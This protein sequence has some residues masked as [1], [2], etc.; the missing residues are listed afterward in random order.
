H[1]TQP[2]KDS[3]TLNRVGGDF[4]SQIDGSLTANGNLIIVNPNGIIFGSSAMVDLGGLIASS[5]NILND[6]FM[7]AGSLKFNLP[8]YKHAAIIN[9]GKINIR[10]AGVLGFVAPHV[11]NAG[12]IKG[13]LSKVSLGSGD[14]FT[15]DLFGDKLIEL[16][17]TD[18]LESQS[19]RM[20]GVIDNKGGIIELSA[21]KARNAIDSIIDV[22]G[23]MVATSIAERDGKII[24]LDADG[25][26]AGGEI[27][28]GGA[29]Q[30]GP[31]LPSS[32][33]SYV[34]PDVKISSSGTNG[35]GGK[36]IVWADKNLVYSGHT[37]AEGGASG[38]GG[39]VE[40]SGKVFTINGSASVKGGL[41]PGEW[42]LDPN[43]ITITGATL[44]MSAGPNFTSTDDSATLNVISI[45]TALD[46]GGDVT[47][48][49]GAG[50]ANSQGGN[51]IIAADIVTTA[52]GANGN[53]TLRLNADRS[54]VNNAVQRNIK[55]TSGKLNVIFN[56]NIDTA[57]TGL[58]GEITFVGGGAGIEA[59]IETK[60][61]NIIF[62]GGAD[63]T[64]G[65][66]VGTDAG[67][68]H[69]TGSSF[70]E[71]GVYLGDAKLLA[72]G[73]NISITGKGWAGPIGYLGVYLN[74]AQLETSGNG[75]ITLKGLGGAGAGGTGISLENFSSLK[76]E[77][78]TINITGTGG[79][80]LN[81]NR[82]VDL[83][84]STIE[85]T[86]SGNINIT[87]TGGGN[88]TTSNDGLLCYQCFIY[89]NN[90]NLT[91]IG[92]GNPTS[93][94][95]AWA[96]GSYMEE[97]VIESKGTGTITMTATS[98][99][100]SG[101]EAFYLYDTII[102]SSIGDI[103]L[104]GSTDGTGGW[105]KG[106][107]F[108]SSTIESTG[109]A[110]IILNGTLTGTSSGSNDAIYFDSTTVKSVSGD[111]TITG[112]T[113]GLGASDDGIV[114]DSTSKIISTGSASITLNG[115]AAA[116]YGILSEA[117]GANVI[118]NAAQ[119]GNIFLTADKISLS[120]LTIA[121]QGNVYMQPQTAGSAI[122][123]NPAGTSY[124]I[125]A[126]TMSAISA[127]SLNFGSSTTGAISLPASYS[128]ASPTIFNTNGATITVSAS[129]S[130]VAA[131][132]GAL[133]FLDPVNLTTNLDTS[134][135]NGYIR[136][137][138]NLNLP[139]AGLTR[140][141]TTGLGAIYLADTTA[142]DNT[143]AFV[144]TG[145]LYLGGDYLST[146]TPLN[147]NR[148]MELTADSSIDTGT[149]DIDLLNVDL[150]TYDL[151]IIGNN[152]FNLNGNIDGI[153][154]DFTT[155][156]DITLGA[157]STINTGTGL[158]DT[159]QI[160][161]G[162]NTLTINGSGL[163]NLRG[164]ITSNNTVITINRPITLQAAADIGNGTADLYLA[165]VAMGSNVFNIY[166][167]GN[168]YL[169]GNYTSTLPLEF[170][171]PI[172]LTG[173]TLIDNGPADI[174]ITK[175]VNLSVSDIIIGT[176]GNLNL[177]ATFNGISGSLDLRKKLMLNQ[178]TEIDVGTGN[179][180][181]IDVEMV[182]HDFK[183]TSTGD[184]HLGGDI[185]G[186]GGSLIFAMPA[187]L[188]RDIE[189]DTTTGDITF[190]GTLNNRYD[191]DITTTGT[192]TFAENVGYESILDTVT[193][194]NARIQIDEGFRARE[195]NIID[196]KDLTVGF[197]PGI[198]VVD[199]FKYRGTGNIDGGILVYMRPYSHP[200][201]NIDIDTT[202]FLCAVLKSY[203]F[204]LKSFNYTKN[205]DS[206]YDYLTIDTRFGSRR[207]CKGNY[208]GFSFDPPQRK[209]FWKVPII[210]RNVSIKLPDLKATEKIFGLDLYA[211]PYGIVKNAKLPSRKDAE[212]D[213]KAL[214]AK[215]R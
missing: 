102:K 6:D 64:T 41:S 30:G 81:S 65:Y 38:K 172:T 58:G 123:L 188:D 143:L 208:L 120:N 171:R 169:K 67:A 69:S 184:L 140:T 82:G 215:N 44:N 214:K 11:E 89:I 161:G 191:L 173:G 199:F 45:T 113:A 75:S 40:T 204:R 42:L 190:G 155:T 126:A 54:I 127:G 79:P 31:S 178:D 201:I 132:S 95:G 147:V 35:D 137:D 142:N 14:R 121:S 25:L 192:L 179:V 203:Y 57:N 146:N 194:Y 164:D 206:P 122:T 62:G 48:T 181:L 149:A 136:F 152:I 24:L 198:E 92:N 109:T 118:G 4:V 5:A 85:A 23:S 138:N 183:V 197:K 16:D 101:P 213:K 177:Y 176:G 160:I 193:V 100:N 77:D 97:T 51:I 166:G 37:K 153:S 12:T 185:N 29:F 13:R 84:Q 9:E 27:Y 154:G 111:I 128:F 205:I 17:V 10:E 86:S 148:N 71:Y 78:G 50:G 33:Y 156:R 88:N 202:G 180:S 105:N 76:V 187:Y 56:S 53:P 15:L 43:D 112:N 87:G 90:G 96:F 80:I 32:M 170:N 83:S 26:S 210:E 74:G 131:S 157:N 174:D 19:L 165:G 107:N 52:G 55:S 158:L 93:A 195:F 91:I 125:A 20:S 130:T 59:V 73:G 39:L 72:D 163:F 110:K 3:I 99:G 211:A 28:V 162:N 139:A 34:G 150:K 70:E 98:R 60:G 175:N 151:N 103:T 209:D 114:L 134:N 133:R 116:G 21:A 129:Q 200:S 196:G 189:I 104:S 207:C 61:G 1:F 182:N 115:T 144:G 212:K 36:V 135:S 2:S 167:T 49:T 8:G 7:R 159:Y 46:A 22:S 63:P 66:A 117:W 124:R 145:L 108:D 186:T 47:V 18:Q 68:V 141:L 94:A 119:T 168:L 106:L